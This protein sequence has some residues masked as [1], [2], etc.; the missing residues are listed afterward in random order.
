MI[1]QLAILANL[2]KHNSKFIAILI[3]SAL[4][5]NL[6]LPVFVLAREAE[7][8]DDRTQRERGL[9]VSD[10]NSGDR[11]FCATNDEATLFL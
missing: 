1:K 11:G 7:E 3:T 8:L 5:F 6:V 2:M 9:S 4:S 10:D